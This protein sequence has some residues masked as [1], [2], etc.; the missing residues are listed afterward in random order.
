MPLPAEALFPTLDPLL[1]YAQYH[2]Q[3]HRYT[4]SVIQWKYKKNKAYRKYTVRC[5]A[6][7][8]YRDQLKGQ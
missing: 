2:A 7:R 5:Y 8:T 6:S 4:V 3:R 1:D